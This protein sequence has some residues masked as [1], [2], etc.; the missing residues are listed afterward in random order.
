M[1]TM[2][3]KTARYQYNLC[4]ASLYPA[5]LYPESLCPATLSP[6]SLCPGTLYPAS[7]CPWIN[8]KN[9]YTRALNWNENAIQY[10]LENP[11]KILIPILCSNKYALDICLPFLDNHHISKEL[12]SNIVTNPNPKIVSII[13]Q[14]GYNQLMFDYMCEN[15]VLIDEI[16]QNRFQ[17]NINWEKLSKNKAAVPFLLK[18]I[19]KICW[20]QFSLNENKLAV[21][22]LI[23]N[24]DNIDWL[25][26]SSNPSAISY[27]EKNLD[28]I[29]FWGLCMNPL[30]IH[31]IEKNIDKCSWITL[32]FNRNALHILEKNPDKIFW[33]N[34]SFNEAIF[35]YDYVSL[36]KERT[37]ILEE[38]LMAVTLHPKRIQWWLENGLTIDDLF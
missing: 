8:E 18:N 1:E 23:N 31:I 5:S 10:L 36:S 24:P 9:L 7:L 20:S 26:F 16:I 11:S 13:R 33:T 17:Y 4:P 28:K 19:D 12:L 38:E 3:Q 32:S 29:I 6:A 14:I 2:M 22:F 37:R 30:A 34:I 15:P 35:E 25:S 27:L 21:K